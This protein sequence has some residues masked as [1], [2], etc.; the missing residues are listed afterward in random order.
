MATGRYRPFV[1]PMESTRWGYDLYR[2]VH[3]RRGAERA[4]ATRPRCSAPTT[5]SYIDNARR[6]R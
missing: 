3:G 1:A 2:A 4:E 6:L 5:L